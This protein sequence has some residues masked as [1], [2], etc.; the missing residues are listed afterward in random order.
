MWGVD[1]LVKLSNWVPSLDPNSRGPNKGDR[2]NACAYDEGSPY[3]VGII[4]PWWMLIG[5]LLRERTLVPL[6]WMTCLSSWISSKEGGL[7]TRGGSAN[8]ARRVSM[9]RTGM[10]AAMM[11]V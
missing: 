9:V 11:C 4:R 8:S 1:L 3:A 6:L 10:E 5:A 7:L 2:A